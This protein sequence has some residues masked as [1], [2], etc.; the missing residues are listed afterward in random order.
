[1]AE[2]LLLIYIV[3]GYWAAEHTIYANKILIG[4]WVNIFIRKL[5]CAI[6][7][8]WILIPIAIFKSL[9]SK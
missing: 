4:T 2:I 8:G 7:I 6:F 1:M 9:K 5:S 3:A